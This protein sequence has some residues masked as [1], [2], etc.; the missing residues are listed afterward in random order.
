MTFSTPTNLHVTGTSWDTAACPGVPPVQV[1]DTDPRFAQILRSRRGNAGCLGPDRGRSPTSGGEGGRRD[2]RDSGPL[3]RLHGNRDDEHRLSL[4]P[5]ELTSV[6]RRGILG[7]PMGSRPHGRIAVVTVL[8]VVACAVPAPASA[9]TVAVNGAP[10]WHDKVVDV[11]GLGWGTAYG[12]CPAGPIEIRSDR[13]EFVGRHNNGH[14]VGTVPSTSVIP[15]SGGF[16]TDVR[17]VARRAAGSATSSSCGGAR[18]P[19]PDR[20][21]PAAHDSSRTADRP[22]ATTSRCPLHPRNRLRGSRAAPSHLRE[23]GGLPSGAALAAPPPIC[24]PEGCPEPR[25]DGPPL[26]DLSP[27]G[28]L[29]LRGAASRACSPPC[30]T[31]VTPLRPAR[32]RSGWSITPAPRSRSAS[33]TSE[34]QGRTADGPSTTTEPSPPVRVLL[35][36]RGLAYG[37]A[38]LNAWRTDF[39]GDPVC[40][41]V[42]S[43]PFA[44]RRAIP[45]VSLGS[46]AVAGASVILHGTGWG[47]NDCDRKVEVIQSRGKADRVIAKASPGDLGAFSAEVDVKSLNGSGEIEITGSQASGLEIADERGRPAKAKCIT[48]PKTAKAFEGQPARS[49]PPPRCR[50]QRNR[51]RLPRSPR[52]RPRPSC[53]PCRWSSRRPATS[54]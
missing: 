40:G 53:P 34:T 30:S 21:R 46:T 15:L 28:E 2:H 36:A 17:L 12:V 49:S 14:L 3:R 25:R 41:Q 7:V 43:A 5:G 45:T 27:R 42:A 44:I 4:G 37:R 9:R 29:W 39:Q 32:S 6:R 35:P 26:Y 51:L 31:A 10:F 8:L 38:V 47:T 16:S 54:T 33:V 18:V 13:S 20:L 48:K 11:G 52:R 22:R 50:R 24:P 1:A 19:V 23:R